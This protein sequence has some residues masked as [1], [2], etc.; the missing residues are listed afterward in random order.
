[1]PILKILPS[2]ID[3]TANY[4]FGTVTANGLDLGATVAAAFNA[5][6]TVSPLDSFARQT[7]NAAFEAANTKLSTSGGTITGNLTVNAIT[8]NTI[9]ANGVDLGTAVASAFLLANNAS[10]TTTSDTAPLNPNVGDT[11]FDTIT[12]ITF[13]YTN[14]GV[15]NNWIDITGPQNAGYIFQSYSLSSNTTSLNE[16]TNTSVLLTVNTVNIADNTA[17]YWTIS[18]ST[19]ADF[20][21]NANTGSVSIINN[22]ATI[23]RT[24]V[25]DL[26]DENAESFVAQLRT[27]STSGPIVA[28]APVITVADTSQAP[29]G[30]S[31]DFLIVG[32]GGASRAGGSNYSS[33]GGGGGF[34]NSSDTLQVGTVYTVTVGAG[35][36][37][38]STSGSQSSIN[39][40]IAGG[41]S[42]GGIYGGGNSGSPQNNTGGTGGSNFAGGGAGAGGN[43]VNGSSGPVIS[44]GNGGLGLFSAVTGSQVGY[45]GGGGGG[46]QQSMGNANGGGSGIG[47]YGGGDS[48][49]PGYNGAVN[50]GGGA[51]GTNPG[52]SGSSGG[53]GVVIFSYLTSGLTNKGQII[54]PT[55]SGTYTSQTNGSYTIVRFTGSGTFTA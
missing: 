19:P 38:G 32:G 31:V 36:S 35:G 1:M 52:N 48:F 16:T 46:G 6:N 10:K 22:S 39:S 12:S 49:F 51:G 25:A 4:A 17:L 33:G 41:G 37:A 5:A 50:R 30:Y 2:A 3:S 55:L 54:S 18:G 34:I 26:T 43:G 20:T 21:D 11:W 23:I 13:R 45:C 42:I 44:G 14:D 47:T 9:T 27:G 40:L 7:A 28:I 8:S 24:L 53:S 29:N 15:S